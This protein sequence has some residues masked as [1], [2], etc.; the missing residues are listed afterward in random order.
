ME[1]QYQRELQKS[2]MILEGDPADVGYEEQMLR[3]NEIRTLLAFYTVELN[4]RIQFW[5]DI[6]GKKSLRDYTEQKG[7]DMAMLQKIVTYLGIAYGEIRKYLIA[8]DH[9]YVSPDTVF[10]EDRESGFLLLLCYCPFARGSL[11][12]QMMELMEYFLTIVDHKEEAVTQACY[13]LYEIVASGNFSMESM[14]EVVSERR[15]EPIP[16]DV[17]ETRS[18]IENL[19]EMEDYDDVF[20]DEIEI[21]EEKPSLSAQLSTLIQDIWQRIFGK[22][23]VTL[24]AKREKLLPG[25]ADCEEFIYHPEDTLYEPTVLLHSDRDQC[26]G[27]LI[28]EGMLDEEDHLIDKD[29]YR[30]GSRDGANDAVLHSTV[31]SRNHAKI[32]RQDGHFYIE[33]LNSTNG[34]YVNGNLLNYKEQVE[35]NTMDQ[36]LFAD[37]AYRFI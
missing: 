33:D 31:V 24:R 28:Y 2:Y 7:L 29:A 5:Y 25:K 26:M 22:A 12:E 27:K 32:S 9:I 3:E 11:Q 23:K 20:E 36:I 19:D 1:I 34:T 10:V 6:T 4:R 17:V 8:Q 37:V 15:E 16:E 14:Q 18:Q 13:K 30:I 21:G 35:L